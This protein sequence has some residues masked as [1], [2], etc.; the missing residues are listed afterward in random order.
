MFARFSDQRE[1]EITFV[2][3]ESARSFRTTNEPER[4]E[5]PVIVAI[6]TSLL[7]RS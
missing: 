5:L 6:I 3:A 1:I 7:A 4:P 2:I